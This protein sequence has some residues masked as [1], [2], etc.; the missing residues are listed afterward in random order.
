MNDSEASF[1]HSEEVL[2]PGPYST[3]PL[4]LASLKNHFICKITS[5]FLN[6]I[7]SQQIKVL[8][9]PVRLLRLC[10]A[11]LLFVQQGG[12]GGSRNSSLV[13]IDDVAIEVKLF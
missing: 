8:I 5:S 3:N 10:D 7:I 11:T 1:D 4:L 6:R 2:F 9:L 13:E 12:R